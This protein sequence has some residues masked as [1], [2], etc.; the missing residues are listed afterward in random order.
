M[1]APAHECSAGPGCESVLLRICIVAG[2]P[3]ARGRERSRRLQ[4]AGRAYISLRRFPPK[5][6]APSSVAQLYF[7][8]GS[9]ANLLHIHA[10]ILCARRILSSMRFWHRC[11]I[12][13]IPCMYVPF[14]TVWS[15]C[16]SRGAST[17]FCPVF[18]F[19]FPLLPSSVLIYNCSRSE[20][21]AF[22]LL[23]L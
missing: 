8:R 11:T 10:M 6:A 15:H 20:S 21:F 23:L 19:T 5:E 4:R 3:A 16:Y 17:S 9:R 14:P 2:C 22:G 12:A 1:R 13:S 18:L 7:A